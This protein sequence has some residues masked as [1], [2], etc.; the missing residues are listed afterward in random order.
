MAETRSEKDQLSALENLFQ[1]KKFSD[2]LDVAKKASSDY[3]NSYPINF[4]YVRTLKALNK[5]AEAEEVLKELML[6]YPN[7]INLLLEGGNVAVLQNKFDEGNEYYNKILFLDPFNTEAKNSIE[8]INVI[9]KDGLVIKEKGDSTSYQKEKLQSADTLPEFD[10]RKLRDIISEEP[11]PPP[12]PPPAPKLSEEAIKEQ[13]PE[14]LPTPPPPPVPEIKDEPIKDQELDIPP[15]PPPPPAPVPELSEEP[16]KEQEPEFPPFSPP[17]VPEVKDEPIKDQELEFLASP[18][19]PPAPVPELS[20]EPIKEQEPELPPFS[21]P[22]VPEMKDEPIKEQE[23]E[24]LPSPPPPPTPEI[25]E[26]PGMSDI[27]EEDTDETEVASLSW[28]KIQEQEMD[29]T[30]IPPPISNM[31]E[32]DSSPGL[33]AEKPETSPIAEYEVPPI[34]DVEKELDE[35]KKVI[36]NQEPEEMMQKE[37]PWQEEELGTGEQGFV[38]ESAAKLYVEQGLLE[39]AVVIYKKL[40]ESRKEERFLSKIEELKRVIVNQKKVRVLNELLN[41]IKQRGE[42][43]V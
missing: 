2:A 28:Q 10:T 36:E 37:E 17:S 14:L 7:N 35:M 11:P 16:I 25:G 42:K 30:E 27:Q 19:P 21:P 13:E 22:S 6:I 24:L 9:K 1:Q 15:S 4:L 39:D 31:V 41:H 43:I 40:Y 32:M 3:P 5:L 18:P 12:P 34:A 33:E 8:K 26:I 23:L 20:E 29:E 38:T